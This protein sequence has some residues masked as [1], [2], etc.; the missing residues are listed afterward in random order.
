MDPRPYAQAS[1]LGRSA[2]ASHPNTQ[3]QRRGGPT[4]G[5]LLWVKGVKGCS[6]S[7]RDRLLASGHSAYLA[8]QAVK[9]RSCPAHGH[10]MCTSRLQSQHSAA[11]D[12]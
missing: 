9:V 6:V 3:G 2:E 1:E 4:V 12:A 10:N 7:L 5:S 8:N 11:S